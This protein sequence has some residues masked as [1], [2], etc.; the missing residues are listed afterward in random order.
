MTSVNSG[1]EK[2]MRSRNQSINEVKIEPNLQRIP[3]K[4]DFTKKPSIIYENTELINKLE[5]EAKK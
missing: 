5:A 2:S 1:E 3:Q 4:S